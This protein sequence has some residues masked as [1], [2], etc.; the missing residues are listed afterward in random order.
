MLLPFSI[1]RSLFILKYLT[2]EISSLK[3]IC[4]KNVI[5]RIYVTTQKARV[6]TL[7]MIKYITS[8][9]FVKSLSKNKNHWWL[10]KCDIETRD[11]TMS[12][13]SSKSWKKIVQGEF[14]EMPHI[15]IFYSCSSFLIHSEKCLQTS[16]SRS[17]PIFS[18]IE[19]PVTTLS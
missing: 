9:D 18:R 8:K 12:Y 5:L 10:W 3:Q 7:I 19:I 16:F 6:I 13:N 2:A 4:K 1:S 14:S 17:I 11:N 15:S